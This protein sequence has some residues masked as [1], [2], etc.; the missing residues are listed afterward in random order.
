MSSQFELDTWR[1]AGSGHWFIAVAG[2]AITDRDAVR[3]GANGLIYQADADAVA[4]MPC[5]GIAITAGAAGQTISVFIQGPVEIP[6]SAWTL[7]GKIYVS[8]VAGGLTQTA[9]A[10]AGDIT[11]EVGVALNATQI[12]FNPQGEGGGIASGCAVLEGSTAYVGFDACKEPF[13]NYFYCDGVADNVQINAAEAYVTALGGGTVELEE[14]TYVLAAGGSIVPTGNDVWF[15]GQGPE[16][17]INGDAL[18]TGQHV[19]F[20]NGR[21]DLTISDMSMQTE[22]GGAKTCHCIFIQDGSNRFRIENV[23]IVDS[24]DDGIHV[25]GTTIDTGHIVHC[26]VLDADGNGILV[27]MDVA[28]LMLRLHIEGCDIR[29]CGTDGMFVADG[30]Y[31]VIYGNVCTDNGDDGIEVS[32]TD[33]VQV[34]GNNCHDNTANGILL[35]TIT[36]S[37]IMGNNCEG[38]SQTGIRVT[39]GNNNALTENVCVGNSQRGIYLSTTADNTVTGNTCNGNAQIGIFS[40]SGSDNTITGNTCSGNSDSGIRLDTSSDNNTVTGNTCNGNTEH[41]IQVDDSDNNTIVGNSCNENDVGNTNSFDGINVTDVSLDNILHSNTCNDNDRYGIYI[42]DALALRNW[43][44]NNQ[45][46]G[47]TSGPFLDTAANLTKLATKTFQFTV[48]GDVEGT[49][50]WASFVSA[51]ASAKGWSVTGA[52]DWAAALSQLPLELQQI[53]R[54]KIWAVALGAPIGGGGQMHLEIVMNAGADDLAFTTEP[55]ALANFDGVTTD[56]VNTD[57]IHWIVDSGDDADIG[58]MVGGMSLE[59]K[60]IYETGADPD[61]ATNAVFRVVEVE[62]V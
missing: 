6:G 12:Y 39:G 5:M 36:N 52:D 18:T 60:V 51:T 45:L 47:N 3:I 41:G 28:N 49:A 46:R 10:G 4:T 32:A 57:V 44:K 17:F 56:Y 9:P 14:G 20:V 30:D 23:T 35:T 27:N 38:N 58:S 22:D 11:Q 59:V 24:D 40:F 55:V 8:T 61:G 2:E 53:V 33:E 62:Y 15:K 48:G 42:D 25:E 26:K 7:G 1:V 19:F 43:V 16:T 50:I 54:F 31:S 21:T 29:G 37:T 34:L 13:T